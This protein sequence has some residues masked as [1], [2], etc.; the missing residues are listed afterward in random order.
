MNDKKHFEILIDGKGIVEKTYQRE[1]SVRLAK[2]REYLYFLGLVGQIGFVIAVPIVAG[3]LIGRYI[4]TKAYTY[5][6]YSLLLLGIGIIVS[7][8]NFYNVV[9][10]II[11]KSKK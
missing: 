5:P 1:K 2:S 4:D 8:V 10:E 7:F 11:K 6:R 9:N 3:L